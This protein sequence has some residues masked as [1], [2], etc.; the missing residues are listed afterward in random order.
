MYCVTRGAY[1]ASVARLASPG[2]RADL[3]LDILGVIGG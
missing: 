1:S 2:G 3:L